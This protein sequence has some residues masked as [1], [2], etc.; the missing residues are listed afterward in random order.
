MPD[1]HG[2]T[3]AALGKV[4]QRQLRLALVTASAPQGQVAS[5]FIEARY[6]DMFG[7]NAP[8]RYGHLLVLTDQLGTTVAA[9]G[10]R[11]ASEG[12]LFLEN[13]LA[14]T[15]EQAI[16]ETAEA[17]PS[18]DT[19][20][21]LGSFAA[22]SSRAATY[23][24]VAMAAY[25]DSQGFSHALVTS[26]GRL[27]RLFALFG[28]DLRCLGDARKDALPDG[29]KNWGLYYDDAPR[30]LQGSVP[31]CFDAVLRERN[32]QPIAARR[33]IIDD[34]ITQARTLSSC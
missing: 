32:R 33:I 5:R 24:I 15:V 23:L 9:L 14:V 17:A 2:S 30:V 18:R 1:R 25:M 19:I 13:Y 26:T 20:V 22:D 3:G 27:R 31:D 10:I 7:S 28:F 21:E 16:A 6:R 12:P 4:E 29:G 34:L 11:R 8:V